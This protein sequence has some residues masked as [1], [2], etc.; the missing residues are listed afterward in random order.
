MTAEPLFEAI[1]EI[2]VPADLDMHSL[3]ERLEEI[4]NDLS[5]DINLED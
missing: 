4:A 1:A 5:V 2:Q 3:H